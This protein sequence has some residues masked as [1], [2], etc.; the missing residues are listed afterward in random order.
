MASAGHSVSKMSEETFDFICTA[1]DRENKTAE[2]VRYCVECSGYCCQPCTDM[3]KKFPTLNHHNLLDV[4]QG[5]QAGKQRTRL[6]EFPT[7]RCDTHQG[8]LLDMYCGKHDVVGCHIC[9][10]K[11][12]R[13]K[14]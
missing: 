3:H 5:N 14:K 13:C 1:C 9:L 12:H 10:S 11:D 8:K 7:E 4:S 6:P 2:A